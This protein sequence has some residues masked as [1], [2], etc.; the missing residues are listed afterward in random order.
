MK[1]KPLNLNEKTIRHIE[2]LKEIM[3]VYEVGANE[4]TLVVDALL[5]NALTDAVK[6]LENKG[7]GCSMCLAH[8]N[9][10]CPRVIEETNEY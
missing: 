10:K 5:Y 1:V 4:T 2:C 7:C 8:N 3:Y 9:M 6:A